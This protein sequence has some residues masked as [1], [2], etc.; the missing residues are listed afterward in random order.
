MSRFEINFSFDS[1]IASATVFADAP[2]IDCRPRSR[3]FVDR[4]RINDSLLCSYMYILY[5]KINTII[6]I[7]LRRVLYYV[8]TDFCPVG[9]MATQT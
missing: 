4:K 8:Q 2:Q 9:R 6:F 1:D 5:I 7:E 3:Y